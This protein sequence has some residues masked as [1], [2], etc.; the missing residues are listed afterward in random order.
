MVSARVRDQI[1][2]LHGPPGGARTRDPWAALRSVA[3]AVLGLLS[4]AAWLTLL[5]GRLALLGAV[6]WLIY[7]STV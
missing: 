2:Q 3:V 6:S 7:R 1:R 4:L 5:I